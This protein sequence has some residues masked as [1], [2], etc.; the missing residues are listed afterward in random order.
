M[1]EKKEVHP[2]LKTTIDRE[3]LIELQQYESI[4]QNPK[5]KAVFWVLFAIA[6][7]L[8]IYIL[9][10][11][12]WPALLALMIFI[13]VNP[14]YNKLKERLVGYDNALA[15]AIIIISFFVILLPA[16]Y[17]MAALAHEAARASMLLQNS[18]DIPNLT[19]SLKQSVDFWPLLSEFGI[20]PNQ[21]VEK[22]V[23]VAEGGVNIFIENL[24]GVITG[25]LGFLFDL[26]L[27]LVILFFML[28]DSAELSKAFYEILPFPYEL[29]YRISNHIARVIRD[30]VYGNLFIMIIQGIFVFFIFLGFG[31]PSPL[32]WAVVGGFFSVIPIISTSVVWLP[33]MIYFLIM[34]WYWQAIM[35]GVLS[36]TIA[37]ILENIVKPKILDKKLNIHP[38]LLFFA[39][40]G[41]L[42]AFG[43]LGL[44]LGPVII[45]L[46]RIF[47]DA[48]KVIE[49][50]S[51]HRKSNPV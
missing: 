47:F 51:K 27:M 29:E 46:F 8:I 9:H 30:V 14:I 5:L 33:A 35:L 16:I 20:T 31:I 36:L 37:Q 42:Q 12:F 4:K 23:T 32:L 39:L 25:S 19:Q 15:G 44:I 21:I 43:L 26:A 3:R 50:F 49:E 40:F 1:Q 6:T 22:S 17:L 38:L 7:S 11:Y 45:T 48:Y 28:V 18:L 2:D 13:I 34:G 10:F 24:T 41:G